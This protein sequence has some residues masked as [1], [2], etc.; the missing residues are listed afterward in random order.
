MGLSQH[1]F[2]LEN[3][4][5]TGQPI[6]FRIPVPLIENIEFLRRGRIQILHTADNFRRAGAAFTI[7]AACLHFHSGLLARRQQQF[8]GF[9]LGGE[10]LR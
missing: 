5:A 1:N 3:L 7:K 9:N 10:V 2:S 4:D 8:T 6:F